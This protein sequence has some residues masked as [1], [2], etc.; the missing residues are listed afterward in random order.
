MTS[1]HKLL[2]NTA[3]THRSFNV[4][5][6]KNTSKTTNNEKIGKNN[7]KLSLNYLYEIILLQI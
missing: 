2:P 4:F 7:F 1:T 5:A 6:N 3:T